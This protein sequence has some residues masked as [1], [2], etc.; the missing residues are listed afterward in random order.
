[1]KKVESTVLYRRFNAKETRTY[2]QRMYKEDDL[3]KE[4]NKEEK[5]NKINDLK[6]KLRDY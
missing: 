4:K 1:M 2:I 6:S 5:E 3:K